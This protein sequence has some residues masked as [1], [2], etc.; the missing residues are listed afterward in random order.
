MP[1]VLSSVIQLASLVALQLPLAFTETDT[2]CFSA[3]T[4]LDVGVADTLSALA[5]VIVTVH[6]AVPRLMV[7][8]PVRAL[9]VDVFAEIV[10]FSVALPV[11]LVVSS[12]IQLASVVAVQPPLAFTVM[13]TV[14]SSA[15]IALL[16][17]VAL[18]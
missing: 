6:E 18:T 9:V 11:P 10:A 3:V 12:A 13:E 2:V 14:C 15:V 1:L 4:L 17:G 7:I 5:C 16:P 8:L